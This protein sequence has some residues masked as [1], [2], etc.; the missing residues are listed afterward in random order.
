MHSVGASSYSSGES[1]RTLRTMSS[2][3]PGI[4]AHASVWT[5]LVRDHDI[6]ELFTYECAATINSYTDSSCSHIDRN[7]MLCFVKIDEDYD[8][9]R[10]QE[11]GTEPNLAS[12]ATLC[13]QP[14]LT[15]LLSLEV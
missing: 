11:Y 2:S 6:L 4:W 1:D 5:D 10:P 14:M 7:L 12:K 9:G 3:L 15:T 8:R 13:D